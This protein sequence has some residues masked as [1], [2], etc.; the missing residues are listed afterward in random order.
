MCGCKEIACEAMMCWNLKIGMIGW[1]ATSFRRACQPIDVCSSFWKMWSI[2]RQIMDVVL[3]G[4]SKVD[5]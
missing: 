3:F 5:I 4:N 2:R 1:Q